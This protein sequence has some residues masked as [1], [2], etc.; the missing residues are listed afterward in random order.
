M[1]TDAVFDQVHRMLRSPAQVGG[2]ESIVLDKQ[3]GRIRT[4]FTCDRNHAWYLLGCAAYEAGRF[5]DAL[6]AFHKALRNWSEDADSMMALA[7]CYSESGRPRWSV[8]YL[9]KA[10]AVKPEDPELLYN[11]GNAY[12]DLQQYS[13]SVDCYERA[14]PNAGPTLAKLCVKNK[15][16]ALKKLEAP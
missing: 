12:F 10:L 13:S 5:R 2:V 6:L 8:F 15:D 11:M 9:G 1:S 14:L 4:P 16:R 7:N 3:T